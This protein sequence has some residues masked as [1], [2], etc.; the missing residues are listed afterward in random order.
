MGCHKM[1]PHNVLRHATE[2]VESL[3]L[4]LLLL[5]LFLAIP[6]LNVHQV[7]KLR[8]LVGRKKW[9]IEMSTSDRSQRWSFEPATQVSSPKRHFQQSW[10]TACDMVVLLLG[11]AV[12]CLGTG[13]ASGEVSLPHLRLPFG[14]RGLQEVHG[15]GIKHKVQQDLNIHE[16][17]TSI[18]LHLK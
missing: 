14:Q 5:L 12:Y 17:T 2:V 10:A 18:Y 7:L 16:Y 9:K 4:G 13:T 3:T 6:R 11:E 8:P 15:L 1:S